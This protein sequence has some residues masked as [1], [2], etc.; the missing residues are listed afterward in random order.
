MEETTLQAQKSGMKSRKVSETLR[1]RRRGFSVQG[2]ANEQTGRAQVVDYID[3]EWYRIG[4][5]RLLALELVIRDSVISSC[6]GWR[7]PHMSFVLS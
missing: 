1:P 5:T 6:V 7:R 4:S 2:R 3:A